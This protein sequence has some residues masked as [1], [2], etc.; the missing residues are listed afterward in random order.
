MVWFRRINFAAVVLCFVVV[1]F[2]AYVRLNNAGLGCPDW[3]GCYG[4]LTVPEAAHEVAAAQQSYPQKPVEAPKAWKE[5]IHRYLATTLGSLIV[6]LALIAWW[7]RDLPL[8]RGLALGV[9]GT[10]LLQGALGALTV[11]WQVNPLTVTAHLLTGLTTLLLLFWMWLSVSPAAPAAAPKVL[12]PLATVALALLVLQIFL[13][14]WTS[15]NYAALG[16]PDFPTCHGSWLPETDL[17]EAFTLWRGLG[18]NYE[19]GVLDNRARVT[20]HLI[21]RIGALAVT[22]VLGWLALRLARAGRR[23]LAAAV[24]AA[25]LLQLG[26]A[27]SMVKLQFP[28]DLA[29]AHNAGA[30][31]LLLALAAVNFAV[32]RPEAA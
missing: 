2:G 5:M 30:A 8:P 12:M 1:V 29:D 7:R 16:C 31:L 19:G 9:L 10:V 17:H 18:V 14:G 21:H 20:I 25:L 22:L 13:G 11:L 26:I 4:Q 15:S 32:R 23:P 6:L 24:I 28:L 27:I 3:P